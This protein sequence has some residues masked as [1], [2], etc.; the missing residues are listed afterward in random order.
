M[1]NAEVLKK[2][3]DNFKKK[4]KHWEFEVDTFNCLGENGAYDRAD[5]LLGFLSN[6]FNADEKDK[7]SFNK[8]VVGVTLLQGLYVVSVKFG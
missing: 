7:Y 3:R 5:S 1:G 8:L 6:S 4:R 2:V